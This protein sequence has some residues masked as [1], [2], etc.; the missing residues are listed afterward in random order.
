MQAELTAWIAASCVHGVALLW[1]RVLHHIVLTRA[2]VQQRMDMQRTQ[3]RE[4]RDG[5]FRLARVLLSKHPQGK[6]IR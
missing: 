6:H 3:S 2:A 4:R 5:L 1:W